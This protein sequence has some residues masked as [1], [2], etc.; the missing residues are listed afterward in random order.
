MGFFRVLNTIV[1]N[2]LISRSGRV[3]VYF[4][5][6]NKLGGTLMIELIL[7]IKVVRLCQDAHL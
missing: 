1:T 3:K 6:F 2:Q 4:V 7:L 5:Y